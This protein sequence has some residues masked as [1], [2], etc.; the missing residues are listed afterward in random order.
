LTA[1]ETTVSL[2]FRFDAEGRNVSVYAPDRVYDDGTGTPVMRAWGARNLRFAER[3][4]V[5]VAT[6]AVAEWYLPS[7]TFEYWRGG[8]TRIEYR[9]GA[10]TSK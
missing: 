4:G 9:Y 1:G 2:E 3:E 8:P 10:P 7:G 5:V 6:E